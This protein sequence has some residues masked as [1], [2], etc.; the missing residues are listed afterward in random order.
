MVNRCAQHANG[1]RGGGRTA[2]TIATSRASCTA[3]STAV[4]GFA[5]AARPVHAGCIYD[6]GTHPNAD[7]T[8]SGFL[9]SCTAANTSAARIQSEPGATHSAVPAQRFRY[10]R[11][12]AE[13]DDRR[14]RQLP[15]P[16]A[17]NGDASTVLPT[18]V[19]V[20]MSNRDSVL[21]N[22]IRDSCRFLLA[23]VSDLRSA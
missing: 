22:G 18:S 1:Q 9:S 20:S 14:R 3:A 10:H 17:V 7:A 11:L 15:V 13:A 16:T 12:S 19:S 5:T 23:E 21:L 6:T 2:A 4:A 8:A